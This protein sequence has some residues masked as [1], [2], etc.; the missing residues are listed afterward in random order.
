MSEKEEE[1]ESEKEGVKERERERERESRRVCEKRL[2]D[3]LN[4]F[5]TNDHSFLFLSKETK[6]LLKVIIVII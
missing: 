6:N 4:K 3:E 5:Y 1:R 2:K